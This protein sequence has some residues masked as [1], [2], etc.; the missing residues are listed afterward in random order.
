MRMERVVAALTGAGVAGDALMLL[1]LADWLAKDV[2]AFNVF[3]YSRCAQC[4]PA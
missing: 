1:W 3:S 4:L 2:R